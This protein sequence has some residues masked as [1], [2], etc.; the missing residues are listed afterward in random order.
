MP[1]EPFVATASAI[2]LIVD[3]ARVPVYLIQAGGPIAAIYPLVALTTAGVLAGTLL[4]QRILVRLPELV[5]RR[6]V[7]VLI[8]ALGISMLLT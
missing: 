4:G 2:A 1:R 7:G 6:A 3:C 8:L 5:F